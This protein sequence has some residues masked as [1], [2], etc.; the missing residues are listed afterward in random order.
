MGADEPKQVP[1]DPDD[2]EVARMRLLEINQRDL[3]SAHSGGSVGGMLGVHWLVG[4]PISA[5]FGMLVG[6]I[7]D[8]RLALGIAL[9]AG[10]AILFAW[11]SREEIDRAK[12]WQENVRRLAPK[13]VAH[14]YCLR[15]RQSDNPDL[16]QRLDYVRRWYLRQLE[17]GADPE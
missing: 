2:I 9:L 3:I 4:I 6:A 11:T 16:W 7:T 14:N 10:P 8:S 1:Y 5:L 12:E 17:S 15:I 13:D